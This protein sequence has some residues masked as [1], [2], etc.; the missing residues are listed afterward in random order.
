M[1]HTAR[2]CGLKVM[3]GCMIESSIGITAASHISPLVDCAD[4]DSNLLLRQDPY[5]GVTIEHG[6]ILLPRA[7]GLGIRE[8]EAG[9]TNG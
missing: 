8:R 2:A 1:I 9:T 4:L 6:K 7:A 3:L 5:A